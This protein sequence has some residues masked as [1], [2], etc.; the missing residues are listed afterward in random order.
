MLSTV[1][2][3][4][5]TSCAAVSYPLLRYLGVVVTIKQSLKVNRGTTGDAI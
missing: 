3:H 1:G 5:G 4:M 2:I